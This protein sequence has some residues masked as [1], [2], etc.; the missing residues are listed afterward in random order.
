M[1]TCVILDSKL[2]S[3][4]RFVKCF[5][6]PFKTNSF[7]RSI[8][9]TNPKHS[10]RQSILVYD[11][12]SRE[13]FE[14]LD[15]WAQVLLASF[16]ANW[17]DM[18]RNCYPNDVSV[19]KSRDCTLRR[20][21]TD[22]RP[23]AGGRQVRRARY[24]GG[25]VRQQGAARPRG[26]PRERFRGAAPPPG[27]AA[28]PRAVR[29]IETSRDGARIAHRKAVS[30]RAATPARPWASLPGSPPRA[31]VARQNA[32]GEGGRILEE[33]GEGGR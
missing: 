5:P 23:W 33:E 18:T 26:G 14:A 32:V 20:M 10:L 11:V 21:R 1:S 4:L 25:G 27:A 6:S 12:G 13:S 28:G 8:H 9:L 2:R 31:F 15:N 29:G 30:G 17:C 7:L 3:I 22:K 16:T 24:G 19:M